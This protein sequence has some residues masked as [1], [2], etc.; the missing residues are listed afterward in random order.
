MLQSSSGIIQHVFENRS[1]GAPGPQRSYNTLELLVSTTDQANCSFVEQLLPAQ[2]TFFHRILVVNQL[3]G[4]P[5]EGQPGV[6]DERA[7]VRRINVNDRGLS[8]SRNI[9]LRC[10]DAD[11]CVFSDDDIQYVDGFEEMIL[12]AHNTFPEYAVILF[13]AVDFNGAPLKKYDDSTGEKTIANSADVYSIEITFKRASVVQAG[14]QFDEMFGLNAMFPLGEER[15][16]IADCIKKGLKV[17][18]IP[19]VMVKHPQVSSGVDIEKEEIN[20]VAQGAVFTRIYGHREALRIFK[21]SVSR[22][23]DDSSSLDLKK[24]LNFFEGIIKYREKTV[25]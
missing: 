9:A 20:E 24:Y 14:I 21:L 13:R 16:F 2:K 5:E 4:F 11:V 12:E 19:K 22:M 6:E 18:E 3:D 23:P 25:G 15:I 1:P 7:G 17:L 8:R 10:A